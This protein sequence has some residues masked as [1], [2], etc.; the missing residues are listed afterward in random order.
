MLL[1]ARMTTSS[2]FLT[3]IASKLTSIFLYTSWGSDVH[4]WEKS[5]P[6]QGCKWQ[7]QGYGN[8][9]PPCNNQIFHMLSIKMMTANELV[10]QEAMTTSIPSMSYHKRSNNSYSCDVARSG[11]IAR[12]QA[13]WRHHRKTQGCNNQT[14]HM[15]W[16]WPQRWWQS[17]YLMLYC[18]E[19]QWWM[20]VDCNKGAHAKQQPTKLYVASQE[21][22]TITERDHLQHDDHVL[23]CVARGYNAGNND[24]SRQARRIALVTANPIHWFGLTTL[25]ITKV[26]S[27]SDKIDH[28]AMTTTLATRQSL[29]SCIAR[30]NDNK[31][32]NAREGRVRLPCS[33]Q[34][35]M[36]SFV[37]CNNDH[38]VPC[39]N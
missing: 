39:N 26:W 18:K 12:E 19:Q 35:F 33:N 5:Q 36:L 9:G 17:A 8:D 23:R 4:P 34:N 28:N 6:L 31:T 2:I 15:L 3:C 13:T 25:M 27:T 29:L 21:R 37:G 10:L 20:M 1:T 22:A 16:G 38:T 7:L 32:I 24:W 14:L 30:N 11:C